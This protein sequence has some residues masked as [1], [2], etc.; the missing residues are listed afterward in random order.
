MQPNELGLT[1]ADPKRLSPLSLFD[2]VWPPALLIVGAGLCAAWIA[3]L[4]YEF[5]GLVGFGL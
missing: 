5:A 4:G 2:R 1:A 3:F